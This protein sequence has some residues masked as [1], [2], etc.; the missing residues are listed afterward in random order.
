[1]MIFEFKITKRNKQG[2]KKKNH[3]VKQKKTIHL[4]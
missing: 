2:L 4:F 3:A 1:M